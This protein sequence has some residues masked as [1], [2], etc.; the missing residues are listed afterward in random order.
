MV[1]TLAFFHKGVNKNFP[2][3]T[4]LKKN[5]TMLIVTA[6]ALIRYNGQILLQKRP[7]GREMAGLW[8]F[9]GG[10]LEQDEQVEQGLARELDEELN[11]LV[12]LED[13]VP[14]CFASAKIGERNMLLL[15][16]SC[17]IWNGEPSAVEGQT[18]GWF[19]FDQMRTLPMPPAD[20]PL[21]DLLDKILRA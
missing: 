15:L 20:L 16:Y 7:E 8:E 9:P 18:L 14:T 3:E 17:R 10:K 5:P 1:T 13:L 21:I 11:I 19:S 12:K 4:K 6:A 2:A